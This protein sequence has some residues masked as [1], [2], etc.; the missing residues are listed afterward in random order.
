MATYT[1]K[2]KDTISQILKNLG[3]SSYN[4]KSSWQAV[5]SASGLA[6]YNKIQPGQKLTIP[7]T[8]L[9]KSSSSKSSSTKKTTTTASKSSDISSQEEMTA[10]LNDYQQQ[11]A[12]LKDYDPFESI[13]SVDDVM[14]ELGMSTEAPTAPSYT[15]LFKTLRES[16]GI[17]NIEAGINEYKD[18]ARQEE[19]LLQQQKTYERGKTTR[20]GVI[21][22]RI[23]QDTQYRQE[24]ISWYNNQISFLTDQANSAYGLIELEM[25][26]TQMDYETAKEAYQTE[27][28]NRLGIYQSIIEQ[29]QDERNYQYQVLQ[30]QQALAST[31]LSMYTNLITSGSL[32]WSDMSS[33]QQT[34]I[35]KME[36]QA[37]LPLGFTSTVKMPAGSNIKQIMQRTDASGSVYADVLYI[38][39]DGSLKV[40]S[41]YTGKTKVTGSGGTTKTTTEDYIGT[42][43]DELNSQAVNGKI[44]ADTYNYYKNIWRGKGFTAEEFDNNFGDFLATTKKTTTTSST[45]GAGSSSVTSSTNKNLLQ[46]AGDWISTAWKS[47]WD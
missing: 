30:D 20:L 5:A 17:D 29:G 42:M 39:E 10:Y 34:M 18:L 47:L 35:H 22:G 13:G 28:T 26:F 45:S 3:S 15:E 7:D 44:S 21:E 24:A 12:D 25:Q 40:D 1:V 16:Y 27:F 32:K 38:A 9:G 37:G 36:I 33:T 8:L 31:N 6:D 14:N 43:Y 11:L 23:D 2:S 46:K 41:I 4:S 19:L